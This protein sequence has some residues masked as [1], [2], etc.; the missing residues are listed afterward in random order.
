MVCEMVKDFCLVCC[1]MSVC[2]DVLSDEWVCVCVCH[3]RSATAV[4]QPSF[5]AWRQ[6]TM[7]DSLRSYVGLWSMWKASRLELGIKWNMAGEWLILL[8]T[9]YSISHKLLK[10]TWLITIPWQ[11][12]QAPNTSSAVDYARERLLKIWQEGHKVS[13]LDWWRAQMDAQE[14]QASFFVIVNEVFHLLCYVLCDFDK[15]D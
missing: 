10:L 9:Y 11:D 6:S 13:C 14:Y 4:A 15:K 2:H 3:D 8:T 5:Q 1:L 12:Q 7:G